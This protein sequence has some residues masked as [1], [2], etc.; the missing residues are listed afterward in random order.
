MLVLLSDAF[1][2]VLYGAVPLWLAMR[3]KNS[4][5]RVDWKTSRSSLPLHLGL[6]F[7]AGTLGLFTLT[8]ILV[9]LDEHG[10]RVPENITPET[11]LAVVLV[12]F[13]FSLTFWYATRQNPG[14]CDLKRKVCA[15][16]VYGLCMSVF[17]MTNLH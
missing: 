16:N 15:A 6:G 4:Y 5:L 10:V 17:F 13:L 9:L 14:L 1:V 3:I 7:I 2:I 12:L 8:G 11:I